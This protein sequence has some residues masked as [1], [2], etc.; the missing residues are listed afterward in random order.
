M[1]FYIALCL[2]ATLAEDIEDKLPRWSQVYS[3]KMDLYVP[4]RDYHGPLRF[5]YDGFH[6]KARL[7]NYRTTVQQ[8]FEANLTDLWNSPLLT[9]RPFTNE[10]HMNMRY[11]YFISQKFRDSSILPNMRKDFYEYRG[12]E[13][14]HGQDA[15]HWQRIKDTVYDRKEFHIWVTLKQGVF[16]PLK[17]DYKWHDTRHGN[18]LD[19]HYVDIYDFDTSEIDPKIWDIGFGLDCKNKPKGLSPDNTLDYLQSFLNLEQ[20]D[21]VANEFDSFKMKFNKMYQSEEENNKR[22]KIFQDNVRFINEHNKAG[23]SFKLKIN[24]LADRTEEELAVMRG[25][26]PPSGP[27]KALPFPYTAEEIER[28]SQNIPE[29]FDWRLYGAV[30]P[31]KDQG[32]CGS[33][34]AFSAVG[35]VEG[36]LFLRDG[37]EQV[38]RLSEQALVD[39]SNGFHNMGCNGGWQEKAYDWMK[40]HGLPNDDNYGGYIAQDSVCNINNVTKD[41]YVKAYYEIP[42]ADEKALKVSKFS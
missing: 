34:W 30:T 8:Y 10:D 41:V 28:M 15:V 27:S 32:Q 39:C 19:H 26:R 5:W 7:D 40:I 12:R 37:S 13:R 22:L 33:C 24:H 31:V 4:A 38:V 1:L 21:H 25:R 17:W 42:E 36:A 35:A 23:H 16:T 6:D 14:L 11:C 2:A 29:H 9:V 18:L 20:P 3:M